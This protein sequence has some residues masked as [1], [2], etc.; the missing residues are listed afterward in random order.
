MSDFLAE[1]QGQQKLESKIWSLILQYSLTQNTPPNLTTSTHSTLC[2]IYPCNT[3]KKFSKKF[4]SK[5]S[6]KTLAPVWVHCTIS[7]YS[8]TSFSKDLENKCL[9]ILVNLRKKIFILETERF[10]LVVGVLI[11]FL[12]QLA[13]LPKMLQ[14]FFIFKI[15][16]NPAFSIWIF[17]SIGLSLNKIVIKFILLRKHFLSIYDNKTTN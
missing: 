5:S 12:R 8:K 7:R 17:P 1:S 16:G 13:V 4:S 2:K 11:I 3:A 6:D 10:Y 15:F 9:Y 14:F